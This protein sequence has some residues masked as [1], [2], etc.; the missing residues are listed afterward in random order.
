[1][2]NNIQFEKWLKLYPDKTLNDVTK[3]LYIQMIFDNA[4]PDK[5]F[6]KTWLIYRDLEIKKWLDIWPEDNVDDELKLLFISG[7]N[8]SAVTFYHM[9]LKFK[10][11]F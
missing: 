1:M 7:V 9:Y 6:D 10:E 11:K 3:R 5:I 4:V 8:F 2:K